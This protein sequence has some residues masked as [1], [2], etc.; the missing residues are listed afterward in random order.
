MNIISSNRNKD[1]VFCFVDNTRLYQNDFRNL[2]INQADG[3]LATLHLKGYN[4]LQWIDEDALLE[5]A[6]NLTYKY[7]V[8]FSTGTEF[9]NGNSFFN[10]LKD[11]IKQDFFIAG[12]ILDRGDAYYELHHQCYVVNLEYYKKLDKPKIGKQNLG[13]KHKQ[14]IPWRSGENWHDD[15]TPKWVSVG[16]DSREYSHQCHGWNILSVGFEQDLPM[17]VFDESIRNNKK[18]FYPESPT[19]FYKNLSWA[20][21]RLHYCRENFI[22]TNNTEEIIVP[23]KV[24]KQIVTPASGIWFKNY[25]NEQTKIVMYDYNQSSLDYWNKQYPHYEFILCD[26]LQDDKL[27]ST[28]DTTIEDTLITLSNIFNYEGTYFFYSYNY[29]LHK[30]TSLISKIKTLLPNAHVHTTMPV[31]FTD[32]TPTWRLL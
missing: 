31:K 8:V 28:I 23:A 20:Y 12:H 5:Y 26:L 9:I 11:L 21:N 18:H 4:V 10:N 13:F 32:V 27:L 22:H 14:W 25:S 2:I 19:D 29:R 24:Y 3:V 1:I 15:Y 16:D 6:S 30:E 17:L 7:A